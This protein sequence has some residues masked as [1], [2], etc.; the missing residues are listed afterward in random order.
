MFTVGSVSRQYGLIY[1]LIVS[2]YI[3]QV[4]VST[5]S[6]HSRYISQ[7]SVKS[8]LS[9]PW[10]SIKYQLIWYHP[11]YQPILNWYPI[12]TRPTLDRYSTDNQLTV[13]WYISCVLVN[14]TPLHGRYIKRVLVNISVDSVDHHYLYTVNKSSLYYSWKWKIFKFRENFQIPWVV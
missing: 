5:W 1:R 14:A 11:T 6:I 3:G 13:T 7:Q 2:Q 9:I 10:M 8:W 4:S 12:N